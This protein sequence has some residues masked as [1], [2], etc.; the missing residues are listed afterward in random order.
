MK[1]PVRTRSAPTRYE[2]GPPACHAPTRAP[3]T[4]REKQQLIKA[5][6]ALKAQA[7]QG[8][9]QATLLQEHLPRK[10]EAEILAFIHQLKGRVAREAIQM[11]YRRCR[12]EQTRKEAEI[13]APIEVWTDLAEK[14]T[15]KL[16]ETMTAAFSQVLTIAVTE[17]LGL[18]HSI[19]QKLTRAAE[20]K[21]LPDSSSQRD[22]SPAPDDAA[23]NGDAAPGPPAAAQSSNT[24]TDPGV[25]GEPEKFSVDF[26]KIYKYLS[27]LSRDIKVPE[28]SPCESAVVLDLLMSLPEELSK[29]DYDGLKSHMHRSYRALTARQPDGSR[30]G[31]D[32]GAC[33]GELAADTPS[34]SVACER[35]PSA[36]L[37]VSCTAPAELAQ[38]SDNQERPSRSGEC[39][40]GTQE[41]PQPSVSPSS[42]QRSASHGQLP[43]PI[44]SPAA[45]AQ[46]S[47]WKDLGIC[48]L[49]L[50]L[51]PLELLARKGDSLE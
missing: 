47:V 31:S 16:E 12:E 1:P 5:L 45:D 27:M 39:E 42:A 46:K 22:A 40:Q 4:T 48:P 37:S 7:P 50:F 38:P 25:H 6:K 13:L 18:L 23:R 32:P 21:V 9:L 33:A 35:P 41:P 8:E 51:V 17:P 29:L 11:E 30:K 3:W 28:L 20:K 44:H 34:A 2:T 15:D 14:L 19:P 36:N 49:N 43:P 24:S 10:S 26:E